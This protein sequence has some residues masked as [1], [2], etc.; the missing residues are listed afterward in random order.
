MNSLE[1]M[2]DAICR[3]PPREIPV[4]PFIMTFAASYCDVPYSEYVRDGRI[5]AEAQ[6]RVCK[7]FDLDMVTVSS[8]P[9]REAHDCGVEVGF[10]PDDV[11]YSVRPAIQE[12]EDLRH[13]SVPDP[14][15]GPR[16]ADRLLG[17]RSLVQ[18]LKGTVPIVGWVESPLA[19]YCCL[20]GLMPALADL[21]ERPGF[22]K[23]VLEFCLEMESRFAIA[24]LDEGADIIGVG[25]AVA[26]LI[27]PFHYRTLSL[28]VVRRLFEA[29]HV[30]GGIV[31]YH[32]CGSTTHLLDDFLQTGADIV[33]ID[34]MVDMRRARSVLGGK[35]CIKGNVNPVELLF[36][37]EPD[38]VKSLAKTAIEEGGPDG[39]ILSL[40][41][42][43]A[44][45]TPKENLMAFVQAARTYAA[46]DEGAKRE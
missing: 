28:P 40:G 29:I 31:K 19:E 4:A 11:P 8:D 16:M 46:K 30:H 5:L 38:Y 14:Y 33:V 18:G 17:V 2:M 23:E 6:M 41:C 43:L 15:K 34:S 24:Q 20:R 32:V 44:R 10:P 27:S 7:E 3:R 35:T 45:H 39:F 9:Y 13:L 42:E 25:E 22:V 37:R 26:S 36:A 21:I 1:R 12:E